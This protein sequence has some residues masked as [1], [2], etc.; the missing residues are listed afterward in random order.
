MGPF[1]P[2]DLKP[3]T[4]MHHNTTGSKAILKERKADDTGWWV[5]GGGGLGDSVITNES[6]GWTPDP[7]PGFSEQSLRISIIKTWGPAGAHIDVFD[8]LLRQNDRFR[9]ALRVIGAH[10]PG[11]QTEAEVYTI[12]TEALD[13]A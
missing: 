3:G 5:E 8:T 1:S 7:N 6:A 13:G 11:A 12:V 9:E 10:C 4:L 2:R